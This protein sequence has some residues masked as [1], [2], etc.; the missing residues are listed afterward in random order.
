[1]GVF[2]T[3]HMLAGSKLPVASRERLARRLG[4]A[5]HLYI[6]RPAAQ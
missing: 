3:G 2:H 4:S 5:A 6:V 1:V